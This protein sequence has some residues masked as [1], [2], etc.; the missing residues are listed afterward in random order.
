MD[1]DATWHGGRP[2]PKR[3]CYMGWGPS[4]SPQKGGTAPQFSAHVCCGQTDECIKMPLG[5]KV[6]LGPGDISATAEQVLSSSWD[7]RPFGHNRHG[8]KIGGCAP[9][10]ASANLE[11]VDKFC[12]LGDWVW[13][14]MLMQLWRPES[15]LD[16]INS[17]SWYRCLPRGIPVYRWLGEGGCIVVGCEVVCYTEVRPV[18]VRKE[19]EVALQRAE[20]R[21]VRWMCNVKIKDRVPSKELWERLGI[22]D[23]ILILQQN[24][25]Q[26]YVNALRKEDTDWVKKCMEYEVEGSRPRGRP[27]RTWT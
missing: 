26:W 25:L 18:T 5:M 4:S 16:G 11:L 27:K 6:G 22:D 9:F 1:Q 12:Y 13:M 8:P 2:R 14:D 20:M 24:R 23:I 3:H 17:G 19:N 15:K 21:M 10:G 7:G